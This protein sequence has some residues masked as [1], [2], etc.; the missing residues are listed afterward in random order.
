[1]QEVRGSNPLSSTPVQI[2]KFEILSPL[3][4]S[5]V[6]Q[7]S[8]ATAAGRCTSSSRDLA[9]QPGRG[10]WQWPAEAGSRTV[11]GRPDQEERSFPHSFDTCPRCQRAA[12]STWPHRPFPGDSCCLR[13]SSGHSCPAVLP[14]L[15]VLQV[16]MGADGLSRWRSTVRRA[17]ARRGKLGIP[18]RVRRRGAIGRTR[19]PRC[20]ARRGLRRVAAH[21]SGPGRCPGE[22]DG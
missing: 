19:G 15:S 18:A 13:N 17:C 14:G 6:Q 8:T 10:C 16:S 5:L 1:M 12:P 9:P 11:L 4:T 3:F 22:R 21:R 7:Q 2:D 20:R